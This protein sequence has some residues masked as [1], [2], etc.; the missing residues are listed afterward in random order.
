MGGLFHLDAF[1]FVIVEAE[2]ALRW[3]AVAW[4]VTIELHFEVQ[5]ITTKPHGRDDSAQKFAQFWIADVACQHLGAVR[6]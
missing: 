2:T 6:I 5:P 1:P 4:V 3:A